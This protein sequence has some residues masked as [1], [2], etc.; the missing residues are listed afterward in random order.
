M[1]KSDE[2]IKGC[3]LCGKPPR[4][5]MPIK[6]SFEQYEPSLPALIGCTDCRLTVIF[7]GMLE[8]AMS[9][10]IIKWDNRNYQGQR[11]YIAGLK[12]ALYRSGQCSNTTDLEDILQDEIDYCERVLDAKT[13]I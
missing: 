8:N 4:I 5:K 13:N 3:P 10:A 12:Y 1:S 9:R 2:S 7:P 6:S 11:Q